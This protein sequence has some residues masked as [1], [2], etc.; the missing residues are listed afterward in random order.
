MKKEHN[1]E[2]EVNKEAAAAETEAG[3]VQK[4]SGL[5]H[6]FAGAALTG[7]ALLWKA[8]ILKLPLLGAAALAYLH[9]RKEENA[10]KR[11]NFLW[12]ATVG[13]PTA[14]ALMFHLNAANVAD[15]YI[16]VP[17]NESIHRAQQLPNGFYNPGPALARQATDMANKA[18]DDWD[19]AQQ[20]ARTL[21]TEKPDVAAA[22]GTDCKAV[23]KYRTPR[24][25]RN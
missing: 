1:Q 25:N 2:V 21:C 9:Y 16:Q 6:W 22:A 15:D 18:L 5:K 3:T 19:A 14:L 8:P 17:V 4:S 7:A 11:R 13:A 20:E 24:F 12:G 10:D 23:M